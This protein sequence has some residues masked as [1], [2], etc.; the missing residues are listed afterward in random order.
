MKPNRVKWIENT[1]PLIDAGISRQKCIEYIKE[2]GFHLP[3]KSACIGCPYHS[4]IFWKNLKTK[5]PVQFQNAVDFDIDIRKH[6]VSLKN[7]VY[8][9][10]SLRPLGHI[11][12]DN[13]PDLFEDECEGYCGL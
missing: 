9:H 8:L 13:Q 7:K 1:F 5:E 4:D 3:P 10:R 11:D 2:A 6:R 12:F